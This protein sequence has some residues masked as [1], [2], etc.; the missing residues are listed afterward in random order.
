MPELAGFVTRVR[1]ATFP[2]RALEPTRLDLMLLGRPETELR[3]TDV[4]PWLEG[5]EFMRKLKV[6]QAS[7]L[8]GHDQVKPCAFPAPRHRPGT[9]R[10]PTY[11]NPDVGDA[12]RCIDHE[13]WLQWTKNESEA[14]PVPVTGYSDV[15]PFQANWTSMQ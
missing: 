9:R 8:I 5:M 11:A 7:A 12:P 13:S 3:T 6:S 14:A 10:N 1:V 15:A 4:Y 2:I